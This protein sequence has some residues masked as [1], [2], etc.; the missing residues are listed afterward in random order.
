MTKQQWS[1]N[2]RRRLGALRRRLRQRLYAS[3]DPFLYK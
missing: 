3:R 2:L 1:L